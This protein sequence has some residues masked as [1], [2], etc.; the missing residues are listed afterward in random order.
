MYISGVAK[1]VIS[2]PCENYLCNYSCRPP[3]QLLSGIYVNL[4][5]IILYVFG[6]KLLLAVFGIHFFLK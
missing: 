1:D 3:A 5:Y 2:Y 4:I 6:D